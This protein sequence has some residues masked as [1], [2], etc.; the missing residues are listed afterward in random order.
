M[1]SRIFA[2]LFSASV[3]T[4]G[5]LPQLAHAANSVSF[6]EPA[7]GA[8]VSSPF[9]VKF[10]ISGMAVK[11]AGD[12]TPDTGHHHLL[13]NLD[14]V[15]AGQIIPK[16]T[17]HLHFGNGQ[18]ETTVTLPPGKYQ[19]TMQFGNGMHQSYGPE[20]SKTINVTVE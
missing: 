4:A 15:P 16:D 6:I 7:D 8:V 9:T 19:L 20:L 12:M 10:G 5:F 2:V 13:I 17:Q 1:K 11:P 3:L 14:S 18:T